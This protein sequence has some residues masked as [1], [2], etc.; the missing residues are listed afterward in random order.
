MINKILY[1]IILIFLL[2]CNDTSPI[3]S[4]DN[5]PSIFNG[6]TDLQAC[7][8]SES[9]I[10]DDGSCYYLEDMLQQGY[11]NCYD[12]VYDEC[13]E[14]GG[15]D[16]DFCDNDYDGIDNI[17]DLC[18]YDYDNDLDGDGICGDIDNCPSIENSEQSD[19]DN[20]LYGDECDL[21]PEDPLNECFPD[22]GYSYLV[23]YDWYCT[24]SP[25]TST[26][27]FYGDGYAEISDYSGTWGSDLGSTYLYS[28]LCSSEFLDIDLQFKFDNYNTYYYWDLEEGIGTNSIEGYHDDVTYNGQYNVDGLTSLSTSSYNSS[29]FNLKNNHK[30]ISIKNV[31]TTK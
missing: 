26:I 15:N 5:G 17:F 1:I 6:C 18:P 2:G 28:G 3:N 23:T 31:T 10:I 11:C 19:Q 4:N 8:Y 16:Y 24:G 20:D 14:C 12:D 13:G 30:L 9:A 21:C 29:D 7:N 27:T 22:E 25:G